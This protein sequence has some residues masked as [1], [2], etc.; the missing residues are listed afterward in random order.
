M[1]QKKKGTKSFEDQVRVE[2]FRQGDPLENFKEGPRY[3]VTGVAGRVSVD[4]QGKTYHVACEKSKEEF[5]AHP[6]RYLNK[7][8]RSGSKQD[9][10]SN[11]D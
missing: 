6:D 10:K 9:Q 7:S 2:H 5:L 3:V 4:H 8:T 1:L 11:V